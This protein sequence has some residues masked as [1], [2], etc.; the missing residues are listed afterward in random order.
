L[1]RAAYPAI[2]AVDPTSSV[3]FGALAPRGENATKQN[4]RTMPLAFV[5]SMGCVKVTLKRDRSG[6]CKGFKPLTGDGFAYHPHA[7][8]RAPDDPQPRLDEAAIADLPRL[9]ARST[10]PSGPAA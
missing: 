7:T 4:A 8:T 3:L 9:S 1:V 6:P 10:A 2:K 5:R